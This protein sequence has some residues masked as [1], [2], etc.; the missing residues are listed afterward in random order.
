MNG[1]CRFMR[2][3]RASVALGTMWLIVGCGFASAQEQG[4]IV[5][6][7]SGLIR[8][9]KGAVSRIQFRVVCDE[10]V[11]PVVISVAR[12]SITTKLDSRMPW[13]RRFSH[14]LTSSG[15]GAVG[16]GQ[17]RRG[18]FISC[19]GRRSGAATFTGWIDV[20]PETRCKVPLA[21]SKVVPENGEENWRKR[22]VDAPSFVSHR[23]LFKGRPVGCKP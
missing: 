20:E 13:P 6:G 2:G 8:L 12:L 11:Q 19:R 7:C 18:P 3:I 21:L 5:E 15:P 9:D 4:K 23:P 1:L 10:A 22:V 17:C 14:A 16:T